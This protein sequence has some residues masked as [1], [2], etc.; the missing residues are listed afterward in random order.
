MNTAWELRANKKTR[1][2]KLSREFLENPLLENPLILK[3]PNFFLDLDIFLQ[4]ILSVD[5]AFLLSHDDRLL[6]KNQK[7]TFFKMVNK[8]QK[9]LPVAYIIG[10]KEFWKSE[11]YVNKNVLIP[12]PDTELLIEKALEKIIERSLEVNSKASLEKGFKTNSNSSFKESSKKSFDKSFAKIKILDLC[13]GS[14]CIGLSIAKEI[15]D[16]LK[17]NNIEK[18]FENEPDKNVEKISFDFTLSDISFRSL[19]VAKKNLQKLF[20]KKFGLHEKLSKTHENKFQ[21]RNIMRAYTRNPKQSIKITLLRSNLFNRISSK[22]NSRFHFILTNP[23]YVP[24]KL[25]N[26]LLRDG[27]N[28]PRLALDGGKDGLELIRKIVAKAPEYLLNRAWI[29]IEAGEYN[30]QEVAK[31]LE[32][33]GFSSIEVLQD[34][35]GQDRLIRGQ[36]LE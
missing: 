3:K 10:K 28:E 21:V 11:F 17:N 22:I 34:L 33:R 25:T 29:F 9:G 18:N 12:K 19:R 4:E 32:T 36:W 2:Q 23:P 8:R 31:L 5:R 24:T 1:R 7:N 13:T 15:E 20:P 26:E 27:R 6:N 14:G 35:E 30:A 16:F